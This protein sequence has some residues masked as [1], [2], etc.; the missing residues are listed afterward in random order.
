MVVFDEPKQFVEFLARHRLSSDQFLFM[1]LIYREDYISL[2]KYTEQVKGLMPQEITD[3]VRRGYLVNENK[4][5]EYFADSFTVTEKFTAELYEDALDNAA[6]FWDAYPSYM[7]IDGKKVWIKTEDKEKFLEEYTKK[8]G[9]SHRL[10][11]KV[12]AAL[13]YAKQVNEIH[14][15]IGKWFR[16]EQ[17]KEIEKQVKANT[18]IEG[19]GTKEF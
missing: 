17:W 8:V 7:Y 2:Y 16:S 3:L 12:M 9:Y 5:D 6:K 13:V 11:K 15:G 19:Y 1:F 18:E 4:A 14:M 10:H